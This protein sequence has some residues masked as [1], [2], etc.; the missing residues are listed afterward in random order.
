LGPAPLPEDQKRRQVS[1]RLAPGYV[2]KAKKIAK[3][4]GLAGWGRAVEMALDL[5]IERDPELG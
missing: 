2:E 5:M 1:T 4:K 3:V